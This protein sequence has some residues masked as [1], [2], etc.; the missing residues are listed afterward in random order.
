MVVGSVGGLKDVGKGGSL[1][2]RKASV[3]VNQRG[4]EDDGDSVRRARHM[5]DIRRGDPVW[6]QGAYYASDIHLAAKASK[7]RSISTITRK[8]SREAMAA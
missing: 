1:A 5:D 3:L 2:H 6:P 7:R 4:I 8:D